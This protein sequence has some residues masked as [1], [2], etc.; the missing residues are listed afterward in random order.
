MIEAL[1]TRTYLLLTGASMSRAGQRSSQRSTIRAQVCGL[2]YTQINGQP[3]KP[4]GWT[5][6]ESA[7]LSM[8]MNGARPSRLLPPCFCGA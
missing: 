7:L 8:R 1:F 5:G 3:W 6:G 2:K 4:Q